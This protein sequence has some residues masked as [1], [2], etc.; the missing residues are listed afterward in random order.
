MRQRRPKNLEEKIKKLSGYLIK[1]PESF[2]GDWR[3]GFDLPHASGRKLF[4]EIGSGKGR[5]INELALENKDDLFI[6]F[7]GQDTVILR[8]LEKIPAN[9]IKNLKMCQYY[10]K[11]FG[12]I[13]DR[14]ELDGIYLNF[15]DPW[16]KERH[17]KRRLTSP[18]YLDGY[19]DSLKAGSFIKMKTDNDGLFSYSV[20]EF[21]KHERF[22]IL[23][24]SE[25]LHTSEFNAEKT[26]TE[27][28]KKFIRFGKNINY[29]CVIRK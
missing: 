14:D 21:K 1:D 12:S 11:N 22:D 26:M 20:A 28:E 29:I 25:D 9:G 7:E 15:S 3:S 10:I 24:Y 23:E 18:G 4:L 19:A 13:F 27:Y 16:P 17:E 2:K 5:F 6:G 8:A